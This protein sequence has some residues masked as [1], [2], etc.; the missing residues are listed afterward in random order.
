MR[1]LAIVLLVVAGCGSSSDGGS[2]GGA[3]L[4]PRDDGGTEGGAPPAVVPPPPPAPSC[5]PAKPFGGATAVAELNGADSDDI[6]TDL[7]ADELTILVASNRAG[8]GQRVLVA[9]RADRSSPFGAL[10]PAV[11]DLG[12]THD[13]FGATLSPD[14]L[15][16]VLSIASGGPTDLYV[17][18]RSSTLATFGVPALASGPSSSA[19]DQGPK[20]SADGKTLYFDSTRGG[21]RDLWRAPVTSG[22]FGTPTAIAELASDQ[23]DAIPVV[24]ADEKAIY[25][26]STRDPTADGDIWFATRGDVGKPFADPKPLPGPNVSNAIDAPG[27]VSPDGCTMYLSSTRNGGVHY[28]VFV[29]RRPQ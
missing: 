13:E 26:L 12:T 28:D 21:N 1:R 6:V 15:T 27:W 22:G 19:E 14:R 24:S 25:W 3:I 9:T 23:I 11:S 29:A 5:D 7:S 18:T 4:P 20:L 8:Q 16:L 2:S 17:A 10:T